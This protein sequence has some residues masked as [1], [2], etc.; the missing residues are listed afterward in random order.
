MTSHK[1]IR[2]VRL[3]KN[4]EGERYIKVKGKRKRV[5][6]NLSDKQLLKI[7]LKNIIPLQKK[8][9]KRRPR[10]TKEKGVKAVFDKSGPL[11]SGGAVLAQLIKNIN[12]KKEV[13]PEEL[14]ELK[15]LKKQVKLLEYPKKDIKLLEYAVNNLED[16]V[17]EINI[18]P[19]IEELPDEGKVKITYKDGRSVTVPEKEMHETIKKS[20][21]VDKATSELESAKEKTERLVL[22]AFKSHLSATNKIRLAQLIGD[23]KLSNKAKDVFI[24]T[25]RKNDI[26]KKLLNESQDFV[27]DLL[28]T[29]SGKKQTDDFNKFLH[30][31]LDNKPDEVKQLNEKVKKKKEEL[32]SSPLAKVTEGFAQRSAA[33]EH[34]KPEPT[35][36]SGAALSHLLKGRVQHAKAVQTSRQ[37][38]LSDIDETE[39]Q[40]DYP[41]DLPLELINEEENFTN[42]LEPVPINLPAPSTPIQPKKLFVIPT[43]PQQHASGKNGFVGE[44]LY[45]DQII[46]YMTPYAKDGFKGVISVNEIKELIPEAE[47]KMSFIMNLD[48]DY[49]PGSHWVAVYIDTENDKAIEY[50]DSFADDPPKRFMKD[51]K[52]L[53][54]K[55]NPEEYLK[56]KVN[57][58]IDQKINTADCG[59]FAMKFLIDRYKGLKFKDCTKFS[60]AVKGE[61]EIKLF[62]DK[63]QKFGYI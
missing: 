25:I 10:R 23:P 36:S 53:I 60:D 63:I 21:R 19:E 46:N 57:R 52:L 7:L 58:V 17:H 50:Y 28:E 62:K 29:T 51:I 32:K 42:P 14:K 30:A 8:I 4:K 45:G 48:P 2:P 16:R 6:S 49:K 41:E 47:P 20:K 22:N 27:Q 37:P 59:Y 9:K 61:H 12:E 5:K 39:P 13:K 15:E 55:I 24:D 56:F 1:K 34:K 54:D 43:T 33:K 3:Y 38:S 40:T 26:F 31:K 44:P 11:I 18:G 35:L